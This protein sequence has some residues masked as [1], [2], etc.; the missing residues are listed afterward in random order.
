M[1]A[2]VLRR[3]GDPLQ[4]TDD[5][6]MPS[7][8]DGHELVRVRAVGLCATD[9]KVTG[10]HIDSV[11]TPLVPGHEV[12]GEV[13]T[14]NGSLTT[15]TRV[16]A[17]IFQSC[18]QCPAC[19]AREPNL[20]PQVVRLG[21]ERD[22]GCAE[23]FAYPE[24]ALIP[25]PE[26]TDFSEAAVAMDSVTVP[27]RA[28][29]TKGQIAAGEHVLIVGAGGL[30]L[31]AVQIAVLHGAPVAVIDPDPT[32]RNLARTLGAE[33]AVST[34][35]DEAIHAF[36]PDGVDLAIELSGTE[37]GFTA[38]VESIRPGGRVVVCG[39]RPGVDF[40]ISSTRLAMN[41]RVVMGSRGGRLTDAVQALA[42][43][44]S[45]LVKPIIADRGSLNDVNEFLGRLAAGSA[46]GRLVLVS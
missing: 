4:L 15:G 13:V 14:S 33:V 42:A 1:R 45:G 5:H 17:Y 6:P 43:V 18:G 41:E 3:F 16:A 46:F 29:V 28:L 7:I 2:A 20:C 37:G 34:T 10:G 31:N 38:A 9:L 32:R 21:L 27:W 12:A 25:F 24:A 11:K 39:Y 44:S 36:A 19:A 22:G 35:D 40:A 8:P 30:G 23:Y 26:T